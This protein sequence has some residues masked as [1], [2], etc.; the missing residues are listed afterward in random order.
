MAVSIQ[1]PKAKE[2]PVS[3]GKTVEVP[4][5]ITVRDLAKLM[6]VSPIEIIKELMNNGMMANINQQIDFDTVSIIGEGMG[7][8]IVPIKAPEP[9]P[10]KE[11]KDL[12]LHRRLIANE[13]PS[14]LKPRPPVVTVLGHVDHGKTTL[15]DAIRNTHVVKGEA[16]GITQHI[17]AYQVFLDDR[18]ITFLDTPGHAAFTAMRARGAQATDLAI[19]VVAADDG[20]MPQTR[21][22]VEHARAAQVPIIVALNKI[23]KAN[24]NPDRVKQGLADIGLVVEEWG[25]DVICVPVSAKE[26]QGIGEL[27]ENILLVTDVANLK[28]NPNRLAQG[29]VIEGQ[30]DKRSGVSAT[31][32]VQNGTLNVGDIIVIGTQY[33]RIRAMFNDKGKRIKQAGPS[34][35]VSILGLSEVPE[36]GEFFEVVESERMARTMVEEQRA[37]TTKGAQTTAARPISLEDFFNK[38]QE[39]GDQT[40]NL[41]LKADVQGSV[42]PIVNSLKELG[43]DKLKI[44]ILLEGTG[45]ISESDVNLAIASGA[46]VI[47]FNVSVDP[48]AQ[49]TAE[50]AGVDIRQYDVIYKLI[51][52]VDKALKGLLEPVYGDKTIGRAEVRAVF[53]IPKRGNIAGSYVVE[54]HITRNALARVLRQNK[55][56]HESKI[57]SLKRFTEDAREVATGFE[58]GIGVD[59]FDDFREGD[60]IEAYV[61][62]R[63]N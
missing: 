6:S 63:I 21:E 12:P 3:N 33:S 32:L 5:V 41:I 46:I 50:S 16:G 30:V 34:M 56:L 2:A 22:A 20:V 29:V 59:G 15:L 57:S 35:P 60:I 23:D 31:L 9:E 47:G 11:E 44:K 4:Q 8:E 10:V 24:A 38:T 27:L 25:G 14:K 26:N 40:L 51:D 45:N 17:G 13:D 54:G 53:K 43:D 7:F 39:N 36:A 55:V 52:D 42:E 48:G 19:L 18:P 37:K 61:K 49:R 58:C 28:A 1:K 62:E